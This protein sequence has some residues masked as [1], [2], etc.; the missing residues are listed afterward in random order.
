MENIY[1]LTSLYDESLPIEIQRHIK[2]HFV[3]RAIWVYLIGFICVIIES[4]TIGIQLW[5]ISL[6]LVMYLI[7]MVGITVGFH[8]LFS[9][10]T[11]QTSQTLKKILAIMGIMSQQGTL[12]FWVA[13]H[14]CHHQY[15]DT[16]GDP[17]SPH[18]NS[19]EKISGFKGFSHAYVGWFLEDGCLPD[20]KIYCKDLLQEPIWQKL[21]DNSL[22]IF[23]LSCL[24]P[25]IIGSLITHTFL[26]LLQGFL[27]GGLFRFIFSSNTGI[28]VNTV[29]HL[30][31]KKMFD[32]NDESCNNLFLAIATLGEGWHNNHHAF[33]NSAKFGLKWWQ[34]DCGY[35]VIKVLEFFGLVW[36]VKT[37]SITQISN[38]KL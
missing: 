16:P 32:N 12:I 29:G 31:G 24:I 20:P 19:S 28:W 13:L 10:K 18:Y 4:F 15:T 30:Y 34:I 17:H 33:T 14:R 9:H 25:G 38:K 26:G 35:W 6:F 22:M 11:F 27:W 5:E 23:G 8:R 2:K 21:D 3:Y 7:C 36:D 37:P 1:S